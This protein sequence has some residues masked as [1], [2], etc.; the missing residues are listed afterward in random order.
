MKVAEVDEPTTTFTDTGLEPETTYS[1]TVSA[2]DE[3]GNEGPQSDA[4][5][6]TTEQ[7][8]PPD[9]SFDGTAEGIVETSI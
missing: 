1:Y 4:D 9:D 7:E 2:V 6:A 5:D 8:P 3:E